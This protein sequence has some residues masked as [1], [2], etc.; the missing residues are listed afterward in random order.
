MGK[1][2]NPRN[3]RYPHARVAKARAKINELVKAG[4]RLNPNKASDAYHNAIMKHGNRKEKQVSATRLASGNR[5]YKKRG[6]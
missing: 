5:A 4:H 6:Q 2:L 1:L 3:P